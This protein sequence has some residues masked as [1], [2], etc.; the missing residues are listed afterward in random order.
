MATI[1]APSQLWRT[2][3]LCQWSGNG[4]LYWNTDSNDTCN[5]FH[6]FVKHKFDKWMNWHLYTARDQVD[7]PNLSF[8]SWN[9]WLLLFFTSLTISEGHLTFLAL[10]IPCFM[11]RFAQLFC[12]FRLQRCRPSFTQLT[13]HNWFI[14]IVLFQWF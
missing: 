14:L 3:L 1:A 4:R 10:A 6:L 8:W 7:Q 9:T 5:K 2:R 11:V 13:A 12:S